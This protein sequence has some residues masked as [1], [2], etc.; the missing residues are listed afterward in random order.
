MSEMMSAWEINQSY[1]SKY[2]LSILIMLTVQ[3]KCLYTQKTKFK[4]KLVKHI[5]KYIKL[6]QIVLKVYLHLYLN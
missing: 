1:K 2:T 4:K 3:S 5:S 6:I